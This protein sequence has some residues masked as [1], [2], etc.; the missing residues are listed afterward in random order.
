MR[1]HCKEGAQ[2]KGRSTRPLPT[3]YSA[4]PKSRRLY[5]YRIKWL[6][7]RRQVMAGLA[8]STWPWSMT[9]VIDSPVAT[10]A[11]CLFTVDVYEATAVYAAA[12]LLG[13]HSQS[14]TA[15]HG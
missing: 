10:T 1:T 12:L 6:E 15:L 8:D 5:V 14:Q 3:P 11:S 9:Q 7:P 2:A 13:R 4:Q